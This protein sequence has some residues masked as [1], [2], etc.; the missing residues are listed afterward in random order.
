MS[1]RET[2]IEKYFDRAVG[3]FDANPLAREFLRRLAKESPAMFLPVAMK[4]LLSEEISNAS[5]CVVNLA[6]RQEELPAFLADPATATLEIAQKLF[7][8]FIEADPAFDV[9]MARRLPDRDCTNH[10]EAFDGLRCTRALDLLDLHSRGRRLLPIL[11]HLPNAG[12]QRVA[13]KAT[14]FVG[15]R[16]R[17]PAWVA[18]LLSRSD[19]RVRASAVE[20]MWGLNTPMAIRRLEKCSEDRNNRVMGNALV[21]LHIADHRSIESELLALSQSRLPNRRSMAAWALAKLADPSQFAG[22]PNG[23]CP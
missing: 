19:P 18:D 8:R 11:S 9:T 6:L 12:D 13:A 14:L 7:K 2:I 10:A 15:R 20:S 4:Y 23:Y 3:E 5:R 21:G 17:N 1:Y 22:H 16:L